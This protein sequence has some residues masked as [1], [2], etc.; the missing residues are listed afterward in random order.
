MSGCRRCTI[1]ADRMAEYR[2]DASMGLVSGASP[3]FITSWL[4]S[5]A[6]K[7]LTIHCK[8]EDVGCTCQCKLPELKDGAVGI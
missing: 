1:A 7:V 3:S 2:E 6:R 5:A 4:R 8:G